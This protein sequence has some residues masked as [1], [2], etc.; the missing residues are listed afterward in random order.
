MVEPS[1]SAG[2]WLLQ[3][4]GKQFREQQSAATYSCGGEV[5][6]ELPNTEVG[7]A[8]HVHKK[9]ALGAPLKSKPVT[10]R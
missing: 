5:L 6:V 7:S 10:I 3:K 8:S 2:A 4:L 1:N 9:P